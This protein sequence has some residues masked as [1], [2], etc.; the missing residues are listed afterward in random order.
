VERANASGTRP[1]PHYG[2]M[3]RRAKQACQALYES[4]KIMATRRTPGGRGVGTKI[5]HDSDISIFNYSILS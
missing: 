3:R 4:L 2:S 5:N 1:K